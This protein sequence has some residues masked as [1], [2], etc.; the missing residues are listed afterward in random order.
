MF[1]CGNGEKTGRFH[2][3]L[4]GLSEGE[5]AILQ[6]EQDGQLRIIGCAS[7]ALSHS[8]RCYCIMRKELLSVVY[9]LK[10]YRQ[11]LL[12]RTIVVRTDHAALTYLMKTPKPIGQQGHW[13]DLLLEY[14]ITIQHRPGQVHGNSAA[15]MRAQR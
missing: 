15:A 4:C 9:G 1:E 2:A 12:G 13:L 6:Q 10:K 14:D 5:R 11:H 8:E 7:R 3:I